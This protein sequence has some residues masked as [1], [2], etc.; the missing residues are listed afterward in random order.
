MGLLTG[1]TRAKK[2]IRCLALVSDGFGGFGGIPQYNCDL[3][4][5][6]A[7]SGATELI[8]VLPRHGGPNT[9]LPAGI[10]QSAP[11]GRVRY[12]LA[13]IITALVQRVDVVFCGHLHFAPLAAVIARMRGARLV[14]QAHG[15]EAWRAP[16][17]H[18]RAAIEASDLVLCVSRHTRH[19]LLA[20][21]AIAPERVLVL[22]NTV[23]GVFTPGDGV[24]FRQRN[25]LEN[26]RVLLTVGRLD[27]RERYKGH[28]RIIALL[29]EL[30][31]AGHDVVYLI[32][33]DGDDRARLEQQAHAEGVDQRVR[34]LGNLS[35]TELVGAYRA[36]DL[37]V[38]P[39][40]GEG[41]GISFLEAIACGTPALG[42]EAG[43]A[44]DALADGSLGTLV[45]E[46]ELGVA[47]ARALA[48]PKP[49]GRVLADE[50]RAR[51]GSA[52]FQ[53]RVNALL[54]Y[55]GDR[56]L[57]QHE[58]PRQFGLQTASAG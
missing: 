11:R 40:T 47:I 3:L 31:A 19:A 24:P 20:H 2:R 9:L 33:G 14:I 56:P 7:A 29:P 32:A 49:D 50:V 35:A 5:A 45:S 58:M 23:G 54:D 28:D 10:T 57:D 22:S 44:P 25:G 39:S 26:R 27:S 52:V 43:G 36:A 13:A 37:F 55:L 51:F 1:A 41:F 8:R 34:F 30:V 12:A 42:L 4:T 38:M 17:W 46:Q 18:C 53:E 6:L 48:G 21:S 16:Q 15:I